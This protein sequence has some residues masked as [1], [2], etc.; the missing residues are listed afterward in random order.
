MERRQISI[1]RDWK[2]FDGDFECH[3]YNAVH[4]QF[5][6]PEWMKAGNNGLGYPD[7][8][9]SDW[10]IVRLP[11]DFVIERCEFTKD[12]PASNG[13]LKKGV[14]WY[15]KTFLLPQEYEESRI[16]VRFDGVY[17]DC[18]VWLNGHFSG[19]HL[20]GYMGFEFDVTELAR[21]GEANTLLVRVDANESEGWW[22]EGG[23]IYRDTWIIATPFVH[24]AAHGLYAK[25]EKI[26]LEKQKAEIS[27]I[28]EI[29]NETSS[30]AQIKAFFSVYAPDGSLVYRGKSEKE[31][32]AFNSCVFTCPVSLDRISLWNLEKTQLYRAVVTL[33]SGDETSVQFGLRT[34]E[35]TPE[36][37]MLLN[38]VPTPLKGVCGHDDFAGVGTA[39]NNEV[40]RYKISRLQEIGCN[41]YRCSHN[42]PSP[43]FLQ[44]CDEMG[45]LVIDETRMPG[46]A[47]EYLED[48]TTMIRRDRNHPSV[49][50]WSMGNEEMVMQGTKTGAAIFNRMMNVGKRLDDTRQYLYAINCDFYRI[51]DEDVQNGL[52][53]N[54]VGTNYMV[55]HDPQ[56][57]EKI[58]AS[59]PDQVIVST[60]FSGEI[61]CRGYMQPE[62]TADNI[63]NSGRQ[64]SVCCNERYRDRASCYGVTFPRWG[65]TP[66]ESW[67]ISQKYS[68]HAGIFLWTGM[69]YRGETFPF[70]WPNVISPYGVIDYCGILKDAAY[71]LQSVWTTQ[72]V[73]H[74]FPGWNLKVP[75]GYPVDVWCYTNLEEVELFLNGES[76]GRK[77]KKP[78]DHL[79][80][81][82]PYKK[83]LLTAVGYRDGKKVMEKSRVTSGNAAAIRM[84]ADRQT[85]RADGDDCTILRVWTVDRDG[86]PVT[87]N[88]QEIRF[89]VQNGEILGTGNGNM[90]SH[91]HDKEHRRKLY[92]GECVVL[93][94]STENPGK[95]RVIGERELLESAVVELDAIPSAPAECLLSRTVTE[96]VRA[97]GMGFDA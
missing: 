86:N 45:M 62:E 53:T 66:E 96:T 25:T 85:L 14:G 20:G 36:H 6:R 95:I 72:D 41:A 60:E 93:I 61:T 58:H 2:F 89:S 88:D 77:R 56:A 21:F 10:K 39:L 65:F 59:H 83:G 16:F 34:I 78:L 29:T 74:I 46:V 48:Y 12:V 68:Y 23:G 47:R 75:D 49:I 9:D 7:Y 13:C 44:A 67:K 82:I 30:D 31:I 73:L 4:A 19:R 71:Y 76:M 11:H 35:W 8:D 38:G 79:E 69:D 27:L 22:Y 15:R 40:I 64:L 17:R 1:N 24:V 3:N 63:S 90:R 51:L 5:P 33:S 70:A 37:G 54:P 92:A 91:E 94:R 87:D 18:Y 28:A 50:L 43:L 55:M 57:F 81:Q 80:W 32:P 84:N 26:S 52:Y 42:P 97:D